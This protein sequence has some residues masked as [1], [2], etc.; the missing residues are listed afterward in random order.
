MA[1]AL[2]ILGWA[3]VFGGLFFVLVA[4]IGAL[5]LPDFY[6]RTHASGAAETFGISLFCLGMGLVNGFNLMFIKLLLIAIF[7][8]F[9]NPVGGH[10]IARAAYKA[11][12]QPWFKGKEEE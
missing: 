5:R 6:S 11:G 12:I 4:A 10:M 2:T 9:A 1:L 8:M 3:L 7:M